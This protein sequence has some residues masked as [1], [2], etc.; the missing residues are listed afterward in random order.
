MG[1]IAD[2]IAYFDTL[3]EQNK[4]KAE[5]KLRVRTLDR[6]EPLPN[7]SHNFKPG[8]V[9]PQHNWIWIVERD[10]KP[11]V[12]LITAPAQTCVFL[13]SLAAADSLGD[14]S[15][16][17]MILFRSALADM[18]KRGYM[19]FWVNLEPARALESK[20]LSIVKR[21]PNVKLIENCTLAIG[22][23]NIGSL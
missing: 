8:T 10:S 19:A 11:I 21:L 9:L 5:A 23:T 15:Q 3:L 14:N 1:S 18:L 13:M 12:M 7:L 17:L 20:L 2:S 4:P 6:D 22:P 16:A